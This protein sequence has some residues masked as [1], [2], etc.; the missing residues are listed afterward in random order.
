MEQVTST[1]T[2]MALSDDK[3]HFKTNFARVHRK[4]LE[5][6]EEP[7]PLVLQVKNLSASPI[8]FRQI[9]SYLV[10]RLSK[11]VDAFSGAR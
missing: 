5:V 11:E 6:K 7:K 9:S 4:A 1:I 2:I 3:E 8:D 10:K